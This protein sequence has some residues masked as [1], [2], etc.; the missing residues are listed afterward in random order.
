MNIL[1][2]FL[3][4]H[5]RYG[6]GEY[7]RRVVMSLLNYIETEKRNDIKL[8]ALFDSS[9]PISFDDM[10]PESLGMKYG[11]EYLD[12]QEK[13]ICQII[14]EY[15][16]DKFFIA[17]G[18]R[19]GEYPEIEQVRCNVICVTHDMLYE[20]WYT[21]HM[22]DYSDSCQTEFSREELY[23][24]VLVKN[25][26]KKL[27]TD[28]K[29]CIRQVLKGNIKQGAIELNHMNSVM[30]MVNDNP[31]AINIMVSEYSKATMMYNFNIPS[32]RILVLYS[33]ERLET[34]ILP[35]ENP[36]LKELIDSEKKYYLMVSADR[37]YKNPYKA[38]R[39][40]HHYKELDKD[41]YL[42]MLGNYRK[43]LSDRQIN[44]NFLSDSDLA[45]AIKHCY[46][47][48]YP[49]FFE[50]FGYPPLE[51]MRY[52][53]PVLCSNTTSMPEILGDAPIF[54][55]PFFESAIFDALL[56]LNEENYGEYSRKS[57]ER[58]LMVKE[59]Q[60]KDL[61]L[62]LELLVSPLN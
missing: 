56:K 3:T 33:P 7:H 35:I 37:D 49:S 15:K 57:S 25:A 45:H 47:L 55:S 8:Y 26:A 43:P 27:I 53:K 1:I 12:L 44:L 46:A 20:E 61:Q 54:F 29:F 58:Y 42:V 4:A 52:G 41:S 24:I 9:I 23:P 5:G 32:D 13:G 59:R 31:T 19:L 22:F 36:S 18:Q 21:N 38:A 6:S 10:K 39:A 48:L 14:N 28:I 30:K 51:A 17:C 16:I 34:E 62:L 40:F 60:N 50:G 11:I 2:E